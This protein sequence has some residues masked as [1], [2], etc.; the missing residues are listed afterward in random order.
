VTP[1]LPPTCRDRPTPPR[2][3]DRMRASGALPHSES[4]RRRAGYGASLAGAAV[5]DGLIRS[6]PRH[7]WDAV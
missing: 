3:G 5:L 7:R 1:T 6:R 2:S 4:G